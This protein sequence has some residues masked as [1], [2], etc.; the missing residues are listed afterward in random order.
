[1]T[2]MKRS[3]NLMPGFFFDD[4]L[5]RD[6]FNDEMNTTLP[7]VNIHENGDEYH[8]ELAAPGMKKKDFNVELEDQVLKISYEKKEENEEK[9]KEGKYTKREFNY[10]SFERSFM[11]PK[12]VEHDKIQ[13]EYKDGIL[14]LR[15]PKK[16][17]AKNKP[18]RMIEIK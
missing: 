14:R 2:L 13:G 9:D 18:H 1:M 15:I 7:S 6:W 10:S 3:S 5:G 11:L 8:V 16:E 12:S 17:E 4:F